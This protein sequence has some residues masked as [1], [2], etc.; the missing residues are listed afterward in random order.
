MST[1]EMNNDL[2]E[3]SLKGKGRGMNRNKEETALRKYSRV[4]PEESCSEIRSRT[5]SRVELTGW[6]KWHLSEGLFVQTWGQRPVFP[7][8]L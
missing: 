6:W 8:Y 3:T 5:W 7:S 2:Q 4:E 1:G